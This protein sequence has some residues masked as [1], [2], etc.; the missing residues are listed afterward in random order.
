M[1]NNTLWTDIYKSFGVI[2]L[3]LGFL[4]GYYLGKKILNYIEKKNLVE[5]KKK[6]NRESL[7]S[8]LSGHHHSGGVMTAS[9]V[10]TYDGETQVEK[11]TPTEKA[12]RWLKSI[13]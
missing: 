4:F 12:N 8:D 1:N 13:N 11:L 9:T 10:S 7:Y 6:I 5:I 3:S 2:L